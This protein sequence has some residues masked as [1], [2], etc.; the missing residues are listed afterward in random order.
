MSDLGFLRNDHTEGEWLKH[1]GVY[2]ADNLKNLQTL[3]LPTRQVKS[4]TNPGVKS[5]LKVISHKL[6]HLEELEIALDELDYCMVVDQIAEFR[7]LRK[8]VVNLRGEDLSLET[9]QDIRKRLAF[10]PVMEIYY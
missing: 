5:L 1:L 7:K 3:S 6:E 4:I 9:V 10:I 2:V 8:L